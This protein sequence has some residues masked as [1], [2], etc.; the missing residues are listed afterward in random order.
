M[1]VLIFKCI[2]Y[3][4]LEETKRVAESALRRRHQLCKSPYLRFRLPY[5]LRSLQVAA[6]SRKTKLWFFPGGMMK[7]DKNQS[8]YDN[9]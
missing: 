7:R 9:R 5:D 2:D 4:M 3:N 1:K 6:D 8:S